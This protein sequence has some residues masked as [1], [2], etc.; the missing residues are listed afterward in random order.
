MMV[1]LSIPCALVSHRPGEGGERRR[2]NQ[3]GTNPGPPDRTGRTRRT[4]IV[5][6]TPRPVLN[7][8][9]A[10]CGPPFGTKR[11]QVQILSPRLHSRRSEARTRNGAGLFAASTAAKHGK[12]RNNKLCSSGTC[13]TFR[14]RQVPDSP[15]TRFRLLRDTVPVPA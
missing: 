6:R 15:R 14:F 1:L 8:T 11:P 9:A 7:N 2:G 4:P 10:N 13:L 3:K 12:Y 5:L